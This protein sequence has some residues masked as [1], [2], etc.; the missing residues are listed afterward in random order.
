MQFGRGGA[1][2]G[3]GRWHGLAGGFRRRVVV[4]AALALLGLA[5]LAWRS[6]NSVLWKSRVALPI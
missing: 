6:G 1:N 3:S 5:A 4:L 2:L